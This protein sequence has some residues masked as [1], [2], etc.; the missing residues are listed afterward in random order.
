VVQATVLVRAGTQPAVQTGADVSISAAR[1][2]T[3][4]MA[5]ESFPPEPLISNFTSRDLQAKLTD[6]QIAERSATANSGRMPAFGTQLNDQ[7]ISSLT[8]YIRGGSSSSSSPSNVASR[9]IRKFISPAT[10]FCSPFPP[11]GPWEKAPSSSTSHIVSVSGAARG[12]ELFGLDNFA[13]SSFG[14]RY[15]VTDRLSVDVWRSPSFIGRAD[16]VHGGV[17]HFRRVSRGRVQLDVRVSAESQDNFRKN[18]TE[19][20]EAVLSRSL[21][22]HAQIYFVPTAS[23]N[24]RRLV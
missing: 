13:I 22:S 5:E 21:T 9:P 19:N 23:F 16:P 2:A 18:Y 11:V 8:A 4:P 20:L 10:T 1:A 15:G 24:D 3:E 17:Q 6:R 14:V 7:E 12:A